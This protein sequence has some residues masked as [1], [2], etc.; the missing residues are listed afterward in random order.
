MNCYTEIAKNI[1]EFLSLAAA[2]R[3]DRLPCGATGLSHI[4]KA[5]MISSL[6]M[7]LERRALVITPDEAEATKL[8]ADMQGFGIRAFVFP[9]RDFSFRTDEIASREYEHKRLKI[10]GKMLGGDYDA[11][12]L[13]AEAAL[14]FTVPPAMLMNNSFSVAVGEDC[15]TTELITTLLRCGYVRSEQVDG[16]GQFASRGGILDFFPPDAEHPYRIEFWGDSVDS[17]AT[18]DGESQRRLESVDEV[19]ITPAREVLITDEALCALIE[20]HASSIRAR[21]SA[22]KNLNSDIDRLRGGVRLNSADKYMPLIYPDPASIFSYA[23]DCML[24]VCESFGVRD[25]IN[26]CAQINNETIKGLFSDGILCKGLDRYT[27]QPHEML[28][29]YEEQGAIYLD[30]LPRGSFDTPVKEL[31]NF[32]ANQIVPWNGSLSAVVDDLD[33]IRRK[34]HSCAVLAGTD[35]AAKTLADDLNAEGIDALWCPVPPAKLPSKTVCVLTGSFTAGFEYPSAKFT[36]ITYRSRPTGEKRRSASKKPA[37]NAF[38]N[39]DELRRGEYVVHATH[40]IGIFEGITSLETSGTVKDYIKIR[41]DKGDNLYLPVTQLD[42]VSKYIGPHSDDKPLKLSKL[43]GK[44]WQKTRS[45]V[46]SAVKDMAKELIELYSKRLSV[47]GHAFSPDIDMQNDFERRFEFIETDDQLRCI[48]EIK[49]DMEKPYPMDRLLCGDVGFGKTEVALRAVFKCVADGKQCAILVPTTILALQHYQTILRRFE[50]FPVEA[51]M[52]SRFCTK[53]ENDAAITGLRRGSIDIAVGTHRLISK[54]V[55]FRDLGLIIIDEEQRFG[56][57]QKEKLKTLSPAVDVLTLTATPIPRTLNMAM[58]GIRDMSVIEEAPTD[59]LPVQ[60]FVIEHNMGVLV[61]AMEQELRRGGQVYYLYNNVE[62]IERKAAEI[63]ALLPDAVV[64]IGHG[65]MSED[66]LS[67][68][69]R[70]LLEGEIDILV[71]TTIIETGV[72]VPNVNTLIIENADRMGLAQLHQIR[73]RVGRSSRRAS[74]YFTFTRGKQLSEIAS[75]RLDAI[76]EFTEFG[77][78][79]HIA[80]RDLELRGAGNVLG[81]NQ[82]G[83]MESVGYDMYIKLLEQAIS[84]EKGEITEQTEEKDCL[85]DLPIDAHIPE[86]YIESVPQRLQIY[87][88]IAD[89]KTDDDASDVIDELVDRFGDPPA[90]VEGLIRIALLRGKASANDVYEITRQNDCVLLK[91][92]AMN[93]EKIA[94]AAGHFKGRFVVKAGRDVPHIE[95]RLLK[96]EKQLSLIERIFDYMEESDK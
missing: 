77:S 14:Q 33:A 89:I 7:S 82:H 61:Q 93:M 95:V 55:T 70:R 10:L 22:L 35:K 60:T 73:G 1:P 12:V 21:G 26:S 11:V 59:R 9:A 87:R 19:E 85:I 64:A 30:H 56:V 71:C 65:K 76:R 31:V 44:D 48:N 15:D 45:R 80:M 25:K 24:F 67:E 88:R 92:S 58:T 47:K 18:F 54:D 51:A 79:F 96:G 32:T 62:N 13:S 49:K 91:L 78:G 81:A 74:A 86:D 66:E 39:L 16:P 69:W 63:K 94:R 6:C 41:Y 38:N 3:K 2:V 52:L 72:D 37:R 75:R 28:K 84:E 46:K 8:C 4:H 20:A 23:A 17:I 43:G 90:S 34:G 29:Q 36:L 5:H 42:Q 53:K 57:A 83:H 27:L 40:G 68:V 50:G